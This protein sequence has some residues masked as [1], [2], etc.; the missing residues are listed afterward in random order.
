MVAAPPPPPQEPP[1]P[2]PSLP[3]LERQ[4]PAVAAVVDAFAQQAHAAQPGTRTAEE[5]QQQPPAQ[6]S[7]PQSALE[8]QGSP[9][10]CSAH[11]PVNGVHAEQLA[12]AAA[13]AQQKPARHGPVAQAASSAQGAPGGLGAGVFDSEGGGGRGVAEAAALCGAV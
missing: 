2:P 12:R 1:P 13:G 8:A 9:G 6:R 3:P 10:G 5:A 11:A 7:V 4:A